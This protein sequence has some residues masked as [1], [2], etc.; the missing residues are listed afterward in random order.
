MSM[1]LSTRRIMPKRL[2][3]VINRLLKGLEIKCSLKFQII[4]K[5]YRNFEG[6]KNNEIFLHIF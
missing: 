1:K 5:F 3:L 6:K 4:L 2:I